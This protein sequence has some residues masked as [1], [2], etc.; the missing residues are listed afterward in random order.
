MEAQAFASLPDHDGWSMPTTIEMDIMVDS[1][2]CATECAMDF[3]RHPLDRRRNHP[4]PIR[5]H[6]L[7][8]DL[9]VQIGWVYNAIGRY[10]ADTLEQFEVCFMRDTD[11]R[12]E[13][14]AWCRVTAAW[15]E[16]HEQFL[17][18]ELLADEQERRLVAALAYISWG[19]GDCKQLGVP[20]EVASRLLVCYERFAEE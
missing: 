9:L 18:G 11:P 5:N 20:E 17:A 15:I 4:G 3:E 10:L 12:A 2:R 7:P 1:R 8:P 14:A 6:C 13:V 19:V 16:Y